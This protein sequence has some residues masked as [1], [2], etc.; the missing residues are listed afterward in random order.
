[1]HLLSERKN[2]PLEN[3][4]L[5]FAS[6]APTASTLCILYLNEQSYSSTTY[7]YPQFLRF[8]AEIL[9]SCRINFQ[10]GAFWA[11][12]CS[13][14]AHGP[15]SYMDI[16]ALMSHG[17]SELFMTCASD[18]L[19]SPFPPPKNDTMHIQPVSSPLPLLCLLAPSPPAPPSHPLQQARL[20]LNSRHIAGKKG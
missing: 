9:F 4:H 1:M 15:A 18:P 8:S 11:A 16:S 14:F 3:L 7:I 10:T 2:I 19:D 20:Y 6:L 13:R 5:I 17:Q 12:S